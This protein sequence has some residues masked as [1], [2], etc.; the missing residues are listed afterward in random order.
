VNVHSFLFY[1]ALGAGYGFAA[2]VQPGPFQ[3]YVISRALGHG[4]RRTLPA[5][6]AP[7][8]SDAPIVTISL[9]VLS[10]LPAWLQQTLNVAGGL[11]I[12]YLALNTYRNWQ[13][14]KNVSNL[15]TVSTARQG[16]VKAAAVNI[17][18]P[19]PYIYWALVAGPILLAA[20]K[21][22]PAMGVSFLFSFYGAI[23]A[24]L[25]ALILLFS[26]AKKLGARVNH[27]LLGLSVI[28]LVFFGI[29]QLWLAAAAIVR[30]TAG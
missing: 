11:F 7:L 20:W 24:T 1:L 15:E 22:S 29:R 17:L 23:V 4:W 12:L 30:A 28:A 27:L 8:L 13:R 19:A 2:A 6:V 26:S 21:E 10:R 14:Q 25:A 5:S 3:T 9:L 16:V 18:S